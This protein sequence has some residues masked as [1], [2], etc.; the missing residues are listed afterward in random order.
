ARGAGLTI[1]A[2][3]VERVVDHLLQHGRVARPYLGVGML[4]RVAL[5]EKL[6]EK[7][8]LQQSSGL[9]I[10]SVE[11]DGPADRAGIMMG[12]ILLALGDAAIPDTDDAQALFAGLEVGAAVKARILRGGEPGEVEITLGE[13]P[14]RRR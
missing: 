10:L 2:S 8:N 1:P 7:F 11:A 4:N 5:P 3:T 6:R 12:D 13:R 14:A 9:M